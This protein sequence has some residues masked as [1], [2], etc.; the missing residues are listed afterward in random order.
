[1]FYSLSLGTLCLAPPSLHL[2]GQ[3]EVENLSAN[4]FR[5][6]KTR[7]MGTCR[8]SLT[9]SRIHSTSFDPHLAVCLR[10]LPKIGRLENWSAYLHQD[11]AWRRNS[12]PRWSPPPP[13]NT[14]LGIQGVRG[15]TSRNKLI[16]RVIS[17]QQRNLCSCVIQNTYF[18]RVKIT[19]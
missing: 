7:T 16:T 17:F 8:T 3:N 1:M 11:T 14:C 2:A 13:H 10:G 18:Y 4:A 9:V 15:L 6:Q 19:L 12:S 5:M